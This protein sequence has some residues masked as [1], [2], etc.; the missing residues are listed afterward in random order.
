MSIFKCFNFFKTDKQAKYRKF[1]KHINSLSTLCEKRT[2]N[3]IKEETKN[4]KK[5]FKT[6]G[7]SKELICRALA[8]AKEASVRSLKLKPFDVQII[9]ALAL[10]E[11]NIAEMK[12]GEGKTLVAA[13]AAYLNSISGEQVH[14]VTVNSYLVKRDSDITSKLLN[15]LGVTVGCVVDDMSLESKQEQYNCEV[16]YITNHEVGF[17]YLRDNMVLNTQDRTITK[18]GMNYAIID[19]ADSILIDESRT[20]LIISGPSVQNKEIYTFIDK[21]VKK[22]YNNDYDIDEKY[23]NA[24]LTD[25]GIIKVENI[26]KASK[27]I[28][29][30]GTLHEA[31]NISIIHNILQSIKANYIFK[32]NVDYIVKNNK[33]VIIDEFTGRKMEDRRYSDGLHQAIEAKELV[34]IQAENQ[35]IATIT[36]QNLFRM[37]KK[38]AGMTGTA[39]T[40][41][42]ELRNIYNLDVIQI[43]TNKPVIRKDYN[44]EI[45]STK[46]VKY[47]HIIELIKIAQAKQQPVL[48]GTTDIHTSEELSE[49][50]KKEKLEH[51]VLNAKYHEKEALIISEAGRAGRITIATNMAG[52]GTDIKLG[53]DLEYKLSQLPESATLE[54]IEALKRAHEEER[55]TVLKAGGLFVLGSERHES[56]RIDDQLKGRSGRQGDAGE[57]KFFLSL[58]DNLLRLFGGEK[59]EKLLKMFGFKED[60]K[61][62]HSM[63]NKIIKKSQKRIE[64]IHYEMRKNILQYDNIVSEQ[65][66]QIYKYRN[67]FLESK[68]IVE[69]FKELIL[70][71][72]QETHYSLIEKESGEAS[73]D[74]VLNFFSVLYNI[75]IQYPHEESILN[76]IDQIATEI[77]EN[78]ITH[79]QENGDDFSNALRYILLSSIDTAWQEHLYQITH[80]KESIGYRSYAQKNPIYEYKIE[81][82]TLF[83]ETIHRFLQ[84]A[85]FNVA[86]VQCAKVSE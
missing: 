67:D 22:L 14:I 78:K 3:E 32:K 8:N 70:N 16:V 40:E 4:L 77:I 46:A 63:L 6:S 61:L 56:R 57:S 9:G 83:E 65:R 20:P 54:D 31:K 68:E 7:F 2:D 58:E 47:K 73:Q 13:L 80:L 60:E 39:M 10:H 75:N 41:A 33:V 17:D 76:V 74:S 64:N 12:T 55:Q 86:R 59:I 71:F 34:E 23:K 21:I 5:L 44:D 82:F 25:V 18:H 42:T 36:Y 51:N 43:E 84:T 29:Q 1:A 38:L 62:D 69:E 81:T 35:T 15:Q 28:P 85:I 24:Q 27:V 26:L 52:R 72:N 50:L 53:G 48:M 66:E 49:L 11:G 45:Y 37:Y 79:F 30:S 19:E